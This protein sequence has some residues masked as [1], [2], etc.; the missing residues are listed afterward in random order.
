MLLDLAFT[1]LQKC[2]YF[3]T[4]F[5]IFGFCYNHLYER[6]ETET[7]NR[8]QVSDYFPSLAEYGTLRR[9]VF[10]EQAPSG[11]HTGRAATRSHNLQTSSPDNVNL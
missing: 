4:S 11:V 8:L 2:L 5:C 3:W 1:V 10:S 7:S 6:T 9:T